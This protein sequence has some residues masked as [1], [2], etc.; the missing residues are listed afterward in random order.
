MTVAWAFLAVSLVGAAFTATAVLRIRRISYLILPYFF[1]AW[2]TGELAVHHVAWQAAA[3]VA[4]VALGALDAWP[5]LDRPRATS[6]RGRRS[7]WSIAAPAAPAR[8]S[9]R[10]CASTSTR[11]TRPSAPRFLFAAS[12][13]PSRCRSRRRAPPQHHLRS[14]RTPQHP[15]RVPSARRRRTSAP[16]GLR[17]TS[18]RST[19]AGGRSV[20]RT[21]RA[22]R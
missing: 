13:V 6:R 9:R 17:P 16:S 18:S 2:L 20:K 1:G 22:Y 12:R 3:T 7:P 5:G 10:R 21:S 11:A 14:G 19:V 15:R 4:F 8:S